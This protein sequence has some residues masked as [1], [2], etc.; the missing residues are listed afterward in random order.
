[1][2]VIGTSVRRL[3]DPRLL[4]GSGRFVDDVE[5]PGQLWMRVVRSPVAHATI[6]GIDT[7]RAATAPGVS[8]VFTGK[9]LQDVAPIPQRL[10]LT[11]DDVSECLQPVLAQGRVRYVGEPVAMVVAATPYQAEDAAELVRLDLEQLPVALEARSAADAGG[12]T[13]GRPTVATTLNVGYGDVEA[14][15]AAADR[16]VAH[17]FKVGRH[18]GV[19][20]ETRGLL[21]VPDVGRSTLDIW[22][23]TK[24][25]HFNR[26]L[27]AQ[28]AG[29]PEQSIRVHNVDA[30]GGFGIRGEFYPEDFLVPYVA[31]RVGRSVKWIEDR[32]EHLVAANHSRDQEYVLE[33]ALD[34]EGHVLGLRCEMWHDNGAY[35][36]THGVTVPQL[37]ATMLPGPYR[38]DA[39]DARVHVVLTNKTPAGTYRSPGRYEGTFARERLLDIAAAEMG[40]DPLAIR[41]RNLL[42]PADMPHV[43]ELSALGTDMVLDAG[44]YPKLLRRT[45]DA[46]DIAEWQAEILRGRSGGRR[47][48]LGVA[49][50]LEKS[51]L[52]PNESA[53]IEVDPSGSIRVA[54]GGTSLG[55]GIETVMAQI[56]A[57][58]L[59]VDI[60]RIRVVHTDT[61]QVPHGVGSW[62]S[63]ST[64]VGGGAVVVA[65]EKLRRD[66][67]VI[68]ADLLG[69]APEETE[70]CSGGVRV[71]REPKRCVE[72][73]T[74]AAACDPASSARRGMSAGLRSTG[75]FEVEHMTYPYGVHL[76][77]VELDE[78]TGHVQ[79]L[80]YFVGYEV[81]RAIN[82]QL[83][84]GQIRGGIAQGIG[85][86]LYEG[87][88]F[89]E[90]GQPLSTTFMEYLLVTACESPESVGVLITEDAPAPDNPL[91]VRGAGEGGTTAAGAVIANAVADAL[92]D[93]RSVSRLPI[94]PA[95]VRSSLRGQVAG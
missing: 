66:I 79:L 16:V 56:A 4:R 29:I 46:A 11:D 17:E 75:L 21:A 53:T 82:P 64:V 71:T 47:L 19:P 91:G 84:E 88:A 48:G 62:A 8:A 50:F 30:G 35:L 77:M 1:M 61:D 13:S 89:D 45:C 10:E 40:L 14:A 93:P 49:L 39:F 31:V 81:G 51:G 69:C 74:I 15:F 26:R 72:L 95:M 90:Q 78:E 42:R 28:L 33:L 63:R 34:A 36:R 27:L 32:A 60:S 7:A 2:G 38:I 73:E 54:V 67:T 55:Q 6:V 18:S 87:F 9:D 23:Y 22:G 76:A 85:G 52:G 80:R 37:A 5:A 83:V 25:P 43:R 20:L 24:V 86:A 59:D 3:E 70:Y 44:D 68:G 12:S 57:E 94:T 65:A 41:E 58:S 92:G